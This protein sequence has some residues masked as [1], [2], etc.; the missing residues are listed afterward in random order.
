MLLD[1][2]YASMECLRH[3]LK[4]LRDSFMAV[5]IENRE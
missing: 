5:V 4:L 1:R 2:A 3:V